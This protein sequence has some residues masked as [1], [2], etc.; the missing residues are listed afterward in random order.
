[1]ATDMQPHSA[2][3]NT[4]FKHVAKVLEF[5]YNVPSHVHVNQSCAALCKPAQAAAVQELSRGQSL[6]MEHH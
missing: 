2:V 5:Q 1:M 4:G 6:M 3:E